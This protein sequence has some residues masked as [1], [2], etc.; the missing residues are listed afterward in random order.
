MNSDEE[1][2][3]WEIREEEVPEK[4]QARWDREEA[5]GKGSVCCP[6]CGREVPGD[7]FS[8]L[9]CGERVFE[10]SGLLGKILKWLRGWRGPGR[11]RKSS[12]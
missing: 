9:Y 11:N 8:C 1:P 7:T 3:D 10:D 12:P 4:L 2:K 5:G 6:A